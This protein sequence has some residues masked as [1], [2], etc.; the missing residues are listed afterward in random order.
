MMVHVTSQTPEVMSVVCLYLS[1]AVKI[2]R[3]M[4]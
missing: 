4:S 1:P 2:I 3:L